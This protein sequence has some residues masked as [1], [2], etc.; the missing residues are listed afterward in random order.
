VFAQGTHCTAIQHSLSLLKD[1]PEML[2]ICTTFDQ[3]SISRGVLGMGILSGKYTRDNYKTLLAPD[4]YRLRDEA[5]TRLFH[6]LE[7][8]DK[9]KHVL[10]I[11]GRTIPQGALAWN[12]ARSDRTVPIIGFRT[13]SQIQENIRALEFGPLTNDQMRQIDHLLGR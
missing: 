10:T 1:A 9:I 12:W 13:L 2:E 4:D 7:Q 6:N 5:R 3:A 11:D 8:L